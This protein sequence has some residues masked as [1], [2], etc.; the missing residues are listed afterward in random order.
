MRERKKPSQ[1]WVQRSKYEIENA[2]KL[3]AERQ[4]QLKEIRKNSMKMWIAR[5]PTNR[6]CVFREKPF[7]LMLPELKCEIWVYERDI[8]GCIGYRHFGEELDSNAF[9]EVT[10]ENSPQEVELVI[11]K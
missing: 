3:L 2:D 8:D 11:K 6:L 10:F 4:E 5:T 1:S 9:P 7:L